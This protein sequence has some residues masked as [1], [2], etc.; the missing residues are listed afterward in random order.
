MVLSENSFIKVG[1]FPLALPL[2]KTKKKCEIYLQPT[3]DVGKVVTKYIGGSFM[4]KKVV[5][6]LGR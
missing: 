1:T 6:E 4:L 5:L 3:K 2:C